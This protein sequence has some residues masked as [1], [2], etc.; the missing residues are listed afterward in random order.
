MRLPFGPK[1]GVLVSEG[2]T[3]DEILHELSRD[4]DFVF[5]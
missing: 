1:A 5:G 4:V 3:F 2:R